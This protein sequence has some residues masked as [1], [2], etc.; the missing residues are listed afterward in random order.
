MFNHKVIAMKDVIKSKKTKAIET[1]VTLNEQADEMRTELTKLRQDLVNVKQDIKNQ[2][3][4]QL[5]EAKENLVLAV[6]HAESM[7][8]NAISDFDDLSK[9]SQRDLLTNIPN[10]VLMLERL[11]SAIISARRRKNRIAVLFLDLDHF[12]E[13]NDTLGHATGDKVLQ[14]VA[15]RLEAAIRESDTA[16]RYGGDEFL[17]LLAEISQSADAEQIAE[18]IIKALEVPACIDD[19]TLHL[20]ISIGIAIY[21]DDGKDAAALIDCADKAMYF[22]KKRTGSSFDLFNKE[23]PS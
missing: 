6:V 18:K 3:G 12:K 5:V 23:N 21:P 11:E 7:A 15:S 2:Q 22:S 14:L 20:A 10:R 13:I 8:E 1:L 16:C 9:S 17:I 4:S 19:K